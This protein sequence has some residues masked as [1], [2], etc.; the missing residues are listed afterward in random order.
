MFAVGS[1]WNVGTLPQAK[2]LSVLEALLQEI[3]IGLAELNLHFDMPP[4]YW[5]A[6]K[7]DIRDT[8]A[9]FA[10]RASIAAPSL[11]LTCRLF[12]KGDGEQWKWPDLHSVHARERVTAYHD[13]DSAFDRDP[14]DDRYPF[15]DGEGYLL[16]EA[17]SR[18]SLTLGSE[19]GF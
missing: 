13:R 9:G 12:E 19:L 5:P 16:R 6:D 11:R 17:R 10:H 7:L 18:Q 1:H 2:L 4:V 14:E 15:G 3:P 8:L